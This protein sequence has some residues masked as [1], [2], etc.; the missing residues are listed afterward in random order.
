MEY[1]CYC[2]SWRWRVVGIR[3][4]PVG[5]RVQPWE[6]SGREYL[7]AWTPSRMMGDSG[8]GVAWMLQAMQRRCRILARMN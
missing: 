5:A 3:H 7:E 6:N 1:V 4:Q 8:S 2:H